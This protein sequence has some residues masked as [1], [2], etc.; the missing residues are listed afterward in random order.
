M[1]YTRIL[2]RL[3]DHIAALNAHGMTDGK[4]PTAGVADKLAVANTIALSG[5]AIGTPTPFDGTAPISIPVTSVTGATRQGSLISAK[6]SPWLLGTGTILKVRKDFLRCCPFFV[7]R[8]QQR[9]PRLENHIHAEN[10]LSIHWLKWCGF[11]VEEEVPELLNYEGLFPFR[12]ERGSPN[13]AFPGRGD[14]KKTNGGQK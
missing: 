8:M 2:Q 10:L 5:K 7:E 12:R 11:T 13:N 1:A 9:F 3:L 14:N 4:P 6:G